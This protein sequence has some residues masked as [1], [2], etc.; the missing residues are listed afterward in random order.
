[1]KK[2]ERLVQMKE[3]SLVHQGLKFEHHSLVHLE[4]K[5]TPAMMDRKRAWKQKTGY[6]A[7]APLVLKL[8]EWLQCTVQQEGHNRYREGPERFAMLQGIPEFCL[9]IAHMGGWRERMW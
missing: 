8:A 3:N 9:W 4:L 2:Q 1:V 5:P 7:R 6:R